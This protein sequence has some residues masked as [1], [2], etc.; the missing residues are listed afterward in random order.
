MTFSPSAGFE[1]RKKSTLRFLGEYQEAVK[2]E[3][4]ALEELVSSNIKDVLRYCCVNIA[5]WTDRLGE[6]FLSKIDILSG[7]ELLREIPI[8]TRAQL[9]ANTKWLKSWVRGSKPGQYGESKTSGSTGQPVRVLKYAIEYNARHNAVDLLETIWQKRDLTKKHLGLAQFRKNSTRSNRGEPYEYLSP[10]GSSQNLNVSE[11]TL[12]EILEQ[13]SSSGASSLTANGQIVRMLVNEQLS[14]PVHEIRLDHVTAFADPIDQDLR[15]KTQKAFGAK[16]LNRYSTEEFGYLAIQCSE[17]EHLHALQFLNFIEIVSEDGSPC[18]IGQVGRVVVTSLTN[19]G[20]PLIRYELGDYASWQ[21]P[22]PSGLGLPVLDTEITRMR[23]GMVDGDG[24]SFVPTT[25]KAEFLEFSSI[26]DFQLYLF[27]DTIVGLFAVR[28][29][30]SASERA[31]IQADL[32]KMFHSNLPVK[33]VTT[34]S[35]DWLGSWKR[36]L[37]FKVIGPAPGEI[38][39]QALRSLDLPTP[40]ARAE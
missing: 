26:K 37:F 13:I 15:D 7:Q 17:F 22:C 16:I 8:L 36:R 23:D 28:N 4:E 21:E 18:E 34:E 9:Q 31:Q 14:H 30:L 24:V 27:D 38:T 2:L 39:V 35:L 10:T 29:P 3:R 1:A 12:G 5:W 11:L 40:R 6:D 20:M 33:I 19:P 25:G 32:A